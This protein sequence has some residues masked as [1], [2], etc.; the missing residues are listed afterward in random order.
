[1][2]QLWAGAGFG[3]LWIP[4]VGQEV[5]VAFHD[6]NP[7]QP[8]VIGRVYNADHMPPYALPDQ[9]TKSAIKSASSKGADGFNEIRFEDKKDDEQIFIHA[10]KN[11]DLRV[12]EDR[13]ETI[14]QDSHLIVERDQFEEVKNERHTKIASD[15]VT[16]V[17]KDRHLGVAGKQASKVSGSLSLTVQGDVVE[18][19]QANH[20][21]QTS[22]NYYVKALGVVIESSTGVTI[23]C[24]GSSVVV[25]PAGVTLTGPMVTIDGKMVRI[26]SGPGSPAM[27]GMAG[28]AVSPMAPKAP[29]EADQADPGKMDE[30]KAQQ[31]KAGT[32]K[33]GKAKVTPFRQEEASAASED[34]EKSWIEIELV[35]EEGKPI[36]GERYEI[37]L[38]DGTT[39]AKGT[40]DQN[41]FA[42]VSPIDPGQCE[43]TFPDLDKDAW[44]RA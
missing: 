38:P 1:V 29:E 32:G 2:S 20:S 37:K 21:E 42:R 8:H 5:I 26:A 43:I 19:F 28:S 15:D 13:Y 24:G 41:G 12:K 40:L 30:L 39:V 31:Q 7:D 4:R 6:G 14:V 10:E 33:Y 11:L 16:Q 9:K 18:V 22:M 23:K 3:F 17:G 34:E 25:D 35:D 36:P 27:S 44:K